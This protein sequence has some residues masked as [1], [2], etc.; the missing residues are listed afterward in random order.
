MRELGYVE[1]QDYTFAERYADGDNNR[2]T[3]LA[4]ELLGLKPDIMVASPTVAI[5][6]ASRVMPNVPIVGINMNDPVGVGLIVSEARPGT[7]VTGVLTRVEGMSG[8]QLELVRDIIP[9]ARKIGMLVHAGDP[10]APMQQRDTETAAAKLGM[11]L[12]PAAVQTIDE[13]KNAFQG[14]AHERVDAVTVPGDVMFMGMRSQLAAFGLAAR[15]PTVYNF[16][17]HVIAG[18]LV[19]FGVNL[20]ENYHRG[21]YFVGRIMKGERPAD[22]PVEFATKVELVVNLK[23]AKALGLTIPA[24]LITRAD[25][26]IE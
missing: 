1:G 26:V 18:G 11:S 23:T 10:S 25:E 9:A 17:E 24:E 16:R 21:A 12:S 2:L 22:L 5:L 20:S 8:K 4:Q 19:S 13:V 15:L 6:A 14:F 3:A 7:N